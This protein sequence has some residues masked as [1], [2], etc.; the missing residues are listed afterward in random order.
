VL[1]P[2]RAALVGRIEVRFDRMIE[3][4]ALAEVEQLAA[5]DLDPSLPAMKAIGV[6]EL[7]AA[8]AGAIGFPEAI[9]LAKTATRQYAKRQATWFR[10][11]LGPEWRRVGSAEELTRLDFQA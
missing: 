9:A 11:Q 6:R 10:H 4:G 2:E 5:L 8:M 1:E 3:A 7:Q